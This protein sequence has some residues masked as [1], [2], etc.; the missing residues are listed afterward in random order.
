MDNIRYMTLVYKELQKIDESKAT[1]RMALLNTVIS[2]YATM[3]TWPEQLWV[4]RDEFN[5]LDEIF[6]EPHKHQTA[7]KCLP[8]LA[9][10]S[11][12]VMQENFDGMPIE[13]IL[14]MGINEQYSSYMAA[15]FKYV[16]ETLS[17]E[18]NNEQHL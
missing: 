7:P 17:G 5:E 10:D 2:I 9:Y 13:E 15:Q 6:H 4:T 16:Y 8:R 3:H 12:T 18:T 1:V 14:E 11:I